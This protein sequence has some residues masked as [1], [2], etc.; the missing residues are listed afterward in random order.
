MQ[1]VNVVLSAPFFWYNAIN[2]EISILK[3][4]V[5]SGAISLLFA[6]E[7]LLM[8]LLGQD[9][10]NVCAF[11]DVG[12]MVDLSKEAE[13][14]PQPFRH[15]LGC[16]GANIYTDPL[17]LELKGG[18]TR[19]S[20]ATKRIKHHVVRIGGPFDKTIDELER[21][22]RRIA[23]VFLGPSPIKAGYL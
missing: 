12:A 4:G 19:R 2:G 7:D 11:G 8:G 18:H 9:F 20:T 1:V 21:L 13:G 22:L 17:T 14:I 5:A 3:V 23:E 16:F 10:P 15:E 6:V